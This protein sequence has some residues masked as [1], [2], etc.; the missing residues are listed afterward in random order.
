MPNCGVADT[1]EGR[2]DMIAP[3]LALVMLRMENSAALAAKTGLLTEL[4]VD[5][6]DGQ[7]RE[8]GVGDLVVGKK[9]AS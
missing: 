7:L 2:F 8:S 9:W 4:F 1:V 5:D 3:I 6:M